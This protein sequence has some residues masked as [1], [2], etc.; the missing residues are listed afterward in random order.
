MKASLLILCLWLVAANVA[1]MVP[2]KNAYWRRAY[3]MM[4]LFVPVVVYVFMENPWWVGALAIAAAASVF[5]WPVI[6]FTRWVRRGF[7]RG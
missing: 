7:R 3:V 4:A 6:Y 5:R 1:G 2:S